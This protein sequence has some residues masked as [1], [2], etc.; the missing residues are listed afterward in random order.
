MSKVKQAIWD[1]IE[2]GKEI[3]EVKWPEQKKADEK[4]PKQTI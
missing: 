2:E 3:E 4:Q 1:Q